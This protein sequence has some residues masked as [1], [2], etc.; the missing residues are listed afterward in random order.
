MNDAPNTPARTLTRQKR[1]K[2]ARK[3]GQE[4][5]LNDSATKLVE[6][7]VWRGL[8]RSDA[9]RELGLTDDY[10]YRLLRDPQVMAKFREELATLRTAG[11][12]RM[13]R[14]LEE[15]AMQDDNLTAAVNAIKAHLAMGS[16]KENA[17]A[18]NVAVLTPGWVIDCTAALSGRRGHDSSED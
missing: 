11:D 3:P 6:A 2:P 10:C 14:R 7:M 17:P 8:T 13:L 15:I 12:A 5:G 4:H 18:V 1:L 16:N 9:A